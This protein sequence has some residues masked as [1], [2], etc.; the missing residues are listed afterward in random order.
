MFLGES[1][2]LH[3]HKYHLEWRNPMKNKKLKI[4][5][6]IAITLAIS[7]GI[8]T[9][10]VDAA[11][12]IVV[13]DQFATITQAIEQAGAGDTIQIKTGTYNENLNVNKPLTLQGEE[14]QKTIIIGEG[15]LDRGAQPVIQIISNNVKITGFTIESQNYSTTNLYASGISVQGDHCTIIN[16]I[17]KNTYIGIFCSIQSSTLIK[18]NLITDNL[19]D[20]MRFYGGSL[21]QI[22]NNT[23]TENT[24]SG[25]AMNGY[26]NTILN[27]NITKNL[28]AVGYGGS[29]SLIYGNN[30]SLNSESGL[31]LAGSNNM[32][33][34]NKL[35]S[36]KFGVFVTSQLEAPHENTFY[37]NNFLSNTFNAFD[38]SSSFAEQWNNNNAQGNY[39]SDYKTKYPNA[40]ESIQPGIGNTAY[41][42]APNNTDDYPL[43]NPSEKANQNQPTLPKIPEAPPNSLVSWWPFETI[44]SNG[45][46]PDETGRN[47]VALG[48][49]T[50][51][52]SFV[53]QQVEGKVGKAL[54]FNGAFYAFVPASK[55]LETPN[56]VTIEAWVNVQS[57][58]ENVAYNNIFVEVVRSSTALP[59]RT[60]GVAINGETP[61]NSSS[62]VL[63][64]VRAYVLTSTGFNEIATINPIAQNTWVHIVF[65]R[66]LVDGMHI[67][68]DGKEQAV[69]IVSGIQNP[70]GAILRENEIYIGHDS[71]TE[72]DELKISNYVQEASP[73]WMQWWVWAIAAIIA[74]AALL[75]LYRLKK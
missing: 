56:E 54:S 70:K 31:F 3:L 24:G 63:G 7:W 5:T 47:P 17:I 6:I 29:Y 69:Q 49:E 59:T 2:I 60:L 23:I 22:E 27:N 1:N 30:L 39:W 35:S 43:L 62:P 61:E 21:N 32:I 38:N 71:I 13:P 50:A 41:V 25:I 52:E 4:F 57:L 51:T 55:S 67:S 37:Q 68:I 65:T 26:Q 46:I 8:T 53:P 73:L 75:T 10:R 45:M 9:Q 72:I 36:N 28:R 66:S 48:S 42:I 58:K 20:G 11:K 15:N 33:S 34:G 16:N 64:A 19:K 44:E 14:R 12:T 74:A 40:S 18:D